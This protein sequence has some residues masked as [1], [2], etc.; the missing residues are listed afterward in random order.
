MKHNTAAQS[1]HAFSKVQAPNE[2]KMVHVFVSTCPTLSKC[3]HWPFKRSPVGR[4]KDFCWSP[5]AISFL[6]ADRNVTQNS[7]SMLQAAERDLKL[8][9]SSP[10]GKKRISCVSTSTRRR[11]DDG[12]MQ[13][14]CSCRVQRVHA[15]SHAYSSCVGGRGLHLKPRQATA[16]AHQLHCG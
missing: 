10:T 6:D 12:L 7:R 8:D 4:P 2:E 15:L 1:C 14:C 9:R 11:L 16:D 13:H 3:Q 5:R